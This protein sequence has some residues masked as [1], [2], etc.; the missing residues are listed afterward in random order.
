MWWTG[1]RDNYAGA[2]GETLPQDLFFAMGYGG[3]FAFVLP[4]CDMVVVHRI[5]TPRLHQT[6]AEERPLSQAGP[7]QS[8]S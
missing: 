5:A 8:V 2:F 3:Q 4:S 7:T 1:F 6:G